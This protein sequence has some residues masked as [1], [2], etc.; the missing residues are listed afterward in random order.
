M[1]PSNDPLGDAAR[2]L[3]AQDERRKADRRRTR[4]G[5]K[6]PCPACG[7]YESDVV[8]TKTMGATDDD[9]YRRMRQCKECHARF[10][11]IER[12]ERLIRKG[13]ATSGGVSAA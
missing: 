11:S 1:K 4:N 6:I 5:P 2:A 8:S 13:S 10:T 7:H 9:A 12:V 3:L